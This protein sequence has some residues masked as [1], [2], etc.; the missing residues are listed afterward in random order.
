MNEPNLLIVEDLLL[1]LLDDE[2]GTIAGEGTLHYALGGAVIAEL[3]LAGHVR[4][5][6]QTV[7]HGLKVSAV[8]EAHVSDPLLRRAY[9][10]IA[11]RPRGIQTLLLE[12]G[13]D[14]RSIVLDRLLH[15]GVLRRETRKWLKI[16]TTSRL[17]TNA[18]LHEAAMLEAVRAVLEDGAEPENA[19]EATLVALLSATGT[20]PQF[21][22]GNLLV[23]Q[24]LRPWQGT[25]ECL[26]GS[27]SRR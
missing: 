2:T 21:H 23:R 17:P 3:A 14:L 20:L 22:P 6:E 27:P 19:R 24:S 5:A 1:L 4:T 15:R 9:E 26:L 13:A 11:E 8:S 7:F 10:K 16:F 18:P 12:I 25:R